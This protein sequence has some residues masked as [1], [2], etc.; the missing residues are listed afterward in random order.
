M[1][2]AKYRFFLLPLFLLL[3]CAGLFAQAN[4]QLTGIVTDQTGAVVAGATI[5]LTDPATGFTKST[6]SGATGLYVFGALN[7]ANYNLKIAAKGFQ[8]YEQNGIVVNVSATV[9]ADIKLTVGAETQTV[10]VEANALTVQTDSNVVSTLISSEQISQIATQ[11]RNFAALASL[12]LG[13]SS[14]LP[15]SNTPSSVAANFTISVNGLRQSHNIWLIDGGEADDRGGA[16]GMD[17]MPSQESI[18]EF[19]MLTSNYPPD[20]GISS[21]ATMSLSLK[22]GTQK[23]HGTLFEFNRETAYNAN[24]FF[25]N[26]NKQPRPSLHYNIFGGNIGGPL[27]IPKVYNVNRQKTFFFW[28]EEWRKII[29]AAGTNIQSTMN[30]ADR[31]TAGSSLTYVAPEFTKSNDK[32]NGNQIVVPKVDTS[33][34]YYQTKLKPLG[35]IPGGCWNTA[36]TTYDAKGNAQCTVATGQVIPSSLFDANGVLYL[37]SPALPK[38]NN[39]SDQAVSSNSV[40]LDVRD[41]V[42]RID[43]KFNDKWAILGHY[44]HDTV[45]QGNASPMLGWLWASYNSITSTLSNP[46]NSAAIKMSGTISP[47]LLVEASMN[48][49][50]NVINITNS[51]AGNLPSGWSVTPVASSFKVTKNSLPGIGYLAPYGTAEDTGSAPWHNAAQDYEPKVDVSYTMGKHAMKYGFSYNRYTKN[52]QLFGD[53]QGN[54]GPSNLTNDSAMDILLGLT[55]SYSQFQA[56]PI[57]HYVNQTPSVYAMDNWHVTPRLSL[58]LGLRYDAL[59]HAWER[60]NYV[61]NFDAARYNQGALPKWTNAGTIDPSSAGIST[62]N[63]VQFYLNGMGQAGKYGFP[64]GLVVNDYRT[65]QPRVGFSEDVFGTGRTVLRGGFGTFFERMQGNDIYNAATNAPFAYN[66]QISNT[67]WSDPGT[68]YQTGNSA[69]AEGFPVFA[70]SVTNLAQDYRAPAVAQYSLGVQHEIKPSVVAVVQYV[71]NLAWHQN[72]QRHINNIDPSLGLQMIPTGTGATTAAI[73]CLAG[74]TNNNVPKRFGDDGAC[75]PGFG[76]KTAAGAPLY[77]GGLNQFRSYQGYGDINQQENTT[78]GTYNG[79]QAGVRLQNRWGLSGELDYTYSHEIDITSYDLNGVDNPWNLKYD[80]GSGALDRRHIWSANYIYQLPFFNKDQGLVKTL[81]GGWEIAGT[82]VDQ[83][84]V[85]QKVTGAGGNYDPVGLGGNYTVRPN[86]SGKMRYNKSMWNYF[87]ANMFSEVQP[88][89]LG[90]PNL[91]FGN[92]GKDA[93]VGP[94]R[95][96]FTT[97]L[98]KSF[99][100]KEICHFELR[101]ESFNTFNHTQKNN[102]NVSYNPANGAPYTG[103]GTGNTFGQVTSTWDPRTLELGGKFVF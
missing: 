82:F 39:S 17:I 2:Q 77:P 87:D 97:S 91:G 19:N 29:N 69:A 33:T 63:S 50:G 52:Q 96:N 99:A 100:I 60:G 25:N 18:A 95:V 54:Y 46:S 41:D 61:A 80:K 74:D 44:M 55:G 94:G 102:L 103:F 1:R 20:Y 8:S 89:W 34:T 26:L 84:G 30:N 38:P 11:N 51:A 37:N 85:P 98:Y 43:H 62:V 12:G 31:P 7:P 35:L 3:A 86:V 70:T 9:R 15:D 4:S 6:E 76:G 73:S 83:T 67:Y 71:G 65:L 75:S 81:L 24:F 59:P 36:Q 68:N 22:S 5:T 13:V 72:I 16:G 14:A 92:A 28:N 78:N 57:R 40:P 66:L 45:T 47:N 56:T 23:F 101:F 53:Q 10:T 64:R 58:Q 48:Y 49:D 21:G 32:P 42:V 93:V 90:G 79:F 88:Q 27:F